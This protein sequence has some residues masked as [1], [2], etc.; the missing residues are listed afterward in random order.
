MS[1]LLDLIKNVQEKTLT[2][3][4]LEDYHTELTSLYAQLCWE[5][6][7]LEKKEAVFFLGEKGLHAELTDVAVKR[8]WRGTED[9][10]RLI[11]LKNY[12]KGTSKVLS[13]LKNRMYATY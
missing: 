3:Q 9:G 10:Q 12:E 11:E 1:K 6:A 2:K 13:S 4:Q 8:K 7:E 5:M